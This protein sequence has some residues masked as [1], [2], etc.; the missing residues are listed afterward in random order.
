MKAKKVNGGYIIRIDKGEEIVESIMSFVEDAKIKLAT[1]QGIGATGELKIGLFKAAEKSYK[2]TVLKGDFEIVSLV[3]NITQMDN[4]PY[5][6]LH[7]T[8]ADESHKCFGGHLNYAKVSATFEGFISVIPDTE[9]E[10]SYNE[11]IGL[12]LFDI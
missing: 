6:H 8:V 5:L 3:G 4:K 7:I 12:N 1:I 11:S 2:A 9:V 10:R